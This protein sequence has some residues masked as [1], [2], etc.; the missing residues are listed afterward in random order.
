MYL[1]YRPCVLFFPLLSLILLAVFPGQ[2]RSAVDFKLKPG[3]RGELCLKCH[4]DFKEKL[5]KRFLHTPVAKRECSGCHDPH[6]SNYGKLLASDQNKVCSTCHAAIVPEAAKS[7]HRVVVEGKCRSC[8]DPHSANHKNNLL[9]AGNELCFRC[10][11]GIQKSLTDLKRPHEPVQ[12]N[13]LQCHNPHA[14]TQSGGLLTVKVPGLCRKCHDTGGK[15]FASLHANYPV[16][17]A[18]CTS[19]HNP[20]GSNR[21]AILF[22]GIHQPVA[23]KMCSQCHQPPNAPD[24]LKARRQGYELCRGCHNEMVNVTMAKERVH[25]P[26]LSGDGCLNCHRP[27]ASSGKALLRGSTAEVCATCHS[28]TAKRHDRSETKHK[29]IQEGNCSACHDPHASSYSFLAKKASTFEMCTSCHDWQKHSS[30]PIGEKMKDPRNPNAS[31]QCLSCH[32]SHGTEYKQM[33]PFVTITSLCVQCH[34]KFKR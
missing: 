17:N 27:H 23:K 11:P 20:H 5:G 31:V 19:C 15:A 28:D 16:S 33:I 12:K 10:H 25:G 18:Q 7:V 22:D 24:A 3:A 1:R 34:E 4:V 2:V 14:S 9:A 30:H 8:H 13:C 26:L 29:P 32:R 6:T 21:E